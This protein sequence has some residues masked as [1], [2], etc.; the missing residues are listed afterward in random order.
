MAGLWGAPDQAEP[1]RSTIPIEKLID[2]AYAPEFAETAEPM[3]PS[4]PGGHSADNA[5]ADAIAATLGDRNG[6]LEFDDDLLKESL[7]E[8]LLTL[9]LLEGDGIHGKGMIESVERLFDVGLSPGTVYPQLHDLEADGVLDVHEMVRTKEYVPADD[10]E[11]KERITAAMH[12][13][14]ALGAFFRAALD[15][16]E[17]Q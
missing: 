1:Q 11:A 10:D 2:E 13:H 14:L 15:R 12:Q 9:V 16:Y 17:A 6:D 8:L 5:V 4:T 3:Q 7:D